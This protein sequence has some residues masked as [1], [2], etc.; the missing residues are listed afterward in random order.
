MELSSNGPPAVPTQKTAERPCTRG[1]D[2]DDPRSSDTRGLEFLTFPLEEKMSAHGLDSMAG[3]FL[4]IKDGSGLKGGGG[5]VLF[6]AVV[7]PF[8]GREALFSS[9]K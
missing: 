5:T 9:T 6:P 2:K 7:S 1:S 8:L 3:H 4:K